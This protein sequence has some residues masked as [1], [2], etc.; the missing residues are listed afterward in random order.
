MR[1]QDSVAWA[2]KTYRWSIR[3]KDK[4]EAMERQGAASIVLDKHDGQWKIV[5]MHNSSRDPKAA[6]PPKT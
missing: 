1:A 3:L 4:P 6:S 2:T 5:N